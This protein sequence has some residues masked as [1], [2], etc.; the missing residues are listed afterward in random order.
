VLLINMRKSGPTD[1]ATSIFDAIRTLDREG[2][3]DLFKNAMELGSLEVLGWGAEKMGVP[4]GLIKIVQK[5]GSSEVGDNNSK[6]A[7]A[8]NAIKSFVDAAIKGNRVP[9]IILDEANIA[10]A[11]ETSKDKIR[12][13]N[14]L[15]CL[16]A[17]TK[18]CC[19]GNETIRIQ[20]SIG[21]AKA[22]VHFNTL[23]THLNMHTYTHTHIL[24]NFYSAL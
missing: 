23:I 8:E 14:I 17:L 9:C 21:H 11:V 24:S 6:A 10:F 15:N 18:V 22:T 13:T 7:I 4:V 5:I 1:L 12:V 2:A 3:T 20:S 16:I 19:N